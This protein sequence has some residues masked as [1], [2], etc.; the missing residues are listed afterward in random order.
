MFQEYWISIPLPLQVKVVTGCERKTRDWTLTRNHHVSLLLKAEEIQ[1]WVLCVCLSVCFSG[2][3]ALHI[4]S[5]QLFCP[6]LDPCWTFLFFTINAAAYFGFS[7]TALESPFLLASHLW[8]LLAYCHL[9]G[10][11]VGIFFKST[12]IIF[13]LN[14]SRHLLFMCQM[15]GL[16]GHRQC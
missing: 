7:C 11:S 8:E 6:W 5:S 4:L 14:K 9:L 2:P 12:L 16:D 3:R 1:F 10:H 13:V 15:R